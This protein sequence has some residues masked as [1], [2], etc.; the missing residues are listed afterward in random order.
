MS[1]WVGCDWDI[2]NNWSVILVYIKE[3]VPPQLS[4]TL[5]TP[6]RFEIF[7]VDLDGVLETAPALQKPCETTKSQELSVF[8]L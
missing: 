4:P 3:Y 1:I 7:F 5:W 6:E 8:S 2:K